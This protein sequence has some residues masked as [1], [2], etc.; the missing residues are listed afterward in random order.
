MQRRWNR[1]W[2]QTCHNLPQTILPSEPNS[3]KSTHGYCNRR[4]PDG[5]RRRNCAQ[6]EGGGV[7][8]WEGRGGEMESAKFK[9]MII[10]TTTILVSYTLCFSL[11]Y[12]SLYD[13]Y[14]TLYMVAGLVCCLARTTANFLAKRGMCVKKSNAA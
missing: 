12:L 6:R 8:N 7:R 1:P 4:M 9:L 3:Y 2:D 13:T 14:D 5:R 11:Y 10:T